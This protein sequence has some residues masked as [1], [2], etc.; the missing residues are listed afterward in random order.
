M[1]NRSA[2]KYWPLIGFEAPRWGVTSSQQPLPSN[3]FGPSRGGLIVGAGAART[4]VAATFSVSSAGIRRA[5]SG[6]IR[7][8]HLMHQRCWRRRPAGDVRVEPHDAQLTATEHHA[9]C[10]RTAWGRTHHLGMRD[11]I[12]TGVG[13]QRR[14]TVGVQRL[15]R[16][17]RDGRR[18][19]VRQV[20]L[21][22]QVDG[23]RRSR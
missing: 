13:L 15:D 16:I 1:A 9:G 12:G 10:R 20:Q 8:L 14:S 11:Q 23:S 18:G 2:K 22:S 6:G 4:A 21:I 5:R 19:D 7:E 17:D 3:Q